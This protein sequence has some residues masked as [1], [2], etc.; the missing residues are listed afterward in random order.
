MTVID[1]D[2][3]VKRKNKREA[4]EVPRLEAM[5]ARWEE[6]PDHAVLADLAAR[7][8]LALRRSLF[9]AAR[10]W[11]PVVIH[12]PEEFRRFCKTRLIPGRGDLAL[13]RL[14]FG[15]TVENRRVSDNAKVVRYWHDH[16][17]KTME[18]AEATPVDEIRRWKTK[19]KEA[20][21]N[22]EADDPAVV[23]KEIGGRPPDLEIRGRKFVP[24]AC[25]YTGTVLA[26]GT[27]KLWEIALPYS[28]RRNAVRDALSR[29]IPE[30][31]I[32]G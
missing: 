26:D 9:E 29:P 24:R 15:R 8:D 13:V 28:T 12:Y 23:L 4:E 2:F 20:E 31:I 3:S 14:L 6:R 5:Y 27:M 25:S 22:A 21:A 18:V 19:P 7:G 32:I 11:M 16:P 1:G 30:T 17:E 10:E